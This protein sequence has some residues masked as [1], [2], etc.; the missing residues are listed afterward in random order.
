[1]EKTAVKIT[2][3][4]Y[5]IPYK[6]TRGYYIG[7]YTLQIDSKQLPMSNI[8]QVDFMLNKLFQNMKNENLAEDDPKRVPNND[9]IPVYKKEYIFEPIRAA[10]KK[11]GSRKNISNKKKGKKISNKNKSTKN[12][13]I[14]KKK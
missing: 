10:A 3:K 2:S 6:N 4:L 1:M 9:I 5:P 7:D 13:T 8:D 11:G 14:N 12:R